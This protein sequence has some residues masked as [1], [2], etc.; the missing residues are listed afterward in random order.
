MIMRMH[1]YIA[2]NLKPIFYFSLFSEVKWMNVDMTENGDKIEINVT[3]C[4]R[5]EHS[6]ID[7]ILIDN[8]K[9]K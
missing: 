5:Q 6:F 2:L 7:T 9:I 8:S 4:L 1:C 3:L